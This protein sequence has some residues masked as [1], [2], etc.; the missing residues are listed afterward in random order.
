MKYRNCLLSAVLSVACVILAGMAGSAALLWWLAN[1]DED[2]LFC[3]NDYSVLGEDREVAW[4][5][6]GYL[7]VID[8]SAI[9]EWEPHPDLAADSWARVSLNYVMA[10]ADSEQNWVSSPLYVENLKMTDSLGNNLEP[11]YT[12]AVHDDCLIF[13]KKEMQ[14]DY[15]ELSGTAVVRVSKRRLVEHSRY[16]LMPGVGMEAEI[17]GVRISCRPTSITDAA[18]RGDTPPSTCW[19]LQFHYTDPAA[20]ERI[21]RIDIMAQDG[22]NLTASRQ[23]GMGLVNIDWENDDCGTF[24]DWGEYPY[25]MLRVVTAEP[26]GER[27]L[28]FC[29]RFKPNE[30]PF[31]YTAEPEQKR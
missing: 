22:V 9:D 26:A 27:R 19:K 12:E 4:V 3:K 16:A 7:D 31:Y 25:M 1:D 2:D 6:A 29:M 5:N 30:H 18:E 21:C 23:E 15:V 8:K 11:H 14:G 20:R 24:N 28:P 13:C 10:P 17:H